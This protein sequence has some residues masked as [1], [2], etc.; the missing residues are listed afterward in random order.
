[1]ST[2]IAFADIP[3]A[4]FSGQLEDTPHSDVHL[5]VGGLM[6]HIITAAQD[7]IFFLHHCNIDRLWNAWL[8]QKQLRADPLDDQWRNTPFSFFDENGNE[9]KLTGCDI[10]RAE[11]QLG[12]IYDQEPQQ[13]K[14]FCKRPAYQFPYYLYIPWYEIWPGPIE[15]P[16]ELGIRSFAASTSQLVEHIRD[17]PLRSLKS[18]TAIVL[19]LLGIEADTQPN[20]YYEVYFGLPKGEK[21][22]FESPFYVGNLSLF[23]RG[24]RDMEENM[25]AHDRHVS[26]SGQV[27]SPPS[28]T[29]KITRAVE[30]A[31]K[32][33]KALDQL[34]VV[35]V[36]RGGE[37]DGRPEERRP[38]TTIRIGR[39]EIGLEQLK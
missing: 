19:K 18:G 20:V 34:N 23:G 8:A 1:V 14:Q 5:A 28:V 31:M 38:T 3:F 22:R 30:A 12:Y 27:T 33:S 36:P 7:P 21:P 24:V 6:G 16:A 39:A 11:Q 2:A 26:K 10:L 35:F 25:R 15:L 29:F 13:I 4:N 9:V 17:N 37:I 32:G